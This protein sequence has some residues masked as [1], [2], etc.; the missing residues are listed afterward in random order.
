MDHSVIRRRAVSRRVP[1]SLVRAVRRMTIAMGVSA[2][3]ELV[4]VLQRTRNAS[5]IKIAA[6]DSTAM[7]IRSAPSSL[8]KELHAQPTTHARTILAALEISASSISLLKTITLVKSIPS[9]SQATV[10]TKA[11]AATHPFSPPASKRRALKTATVAPSPL[12]SPK[13]KSQCRL[14][15]TVESTRKVRHIVTFFAETNHGRR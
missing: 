3:Q 8:R 1:D 9:A 5:T 14:H 13:R 4:S 12:R 7:P 11:L 2:R 6:L 10:S 15:V